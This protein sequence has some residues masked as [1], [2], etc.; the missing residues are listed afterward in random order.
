MCI[1]DEMTKQ[2]GVSLIELIM[3]IVIV[4]AAMVGILSVMNIVSKNNADPVMH[5]QALAIAESLLEE[6]ELQDFSAASGVS[7]TSVSVNNRST[8]YHLVS[9]YSGF[10]MPSPPGIFSLNN[11][12]TPMNGLTGYSAIVSITPQPIIASTTTTALL[13]TVAVTDPSGNTI[14]SV[15]YRADY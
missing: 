13:I 5:K 11:S 4:S 10:S 6:I 2:R 14:K 1:K 12:S 7:H 8:A 9:D 3:F 15:G